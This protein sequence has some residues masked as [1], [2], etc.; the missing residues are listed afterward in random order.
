MRSGSILKEEEVYLLCKS[1]P[2]E[3][4]EKSIQGRLEK[5]LLEHLARLEK[6]I[7]AGR[8]KKR[9]KIHQRIGRLRE[10]YSKV[11][12]YYDMELQE[13]ESQLKLS[14]KR[15]ED[16][17]ERPSGTYLLRTNRQDLSEEEIWQLYSLLTQ[18]E[19]SFRSL[20]S[21]L[22]M[23]PIYHQREGRAEAHIFLSLLA[24]HLLH[25]I[26]AVLR[27]KGDHRSW[28]TIKEALSSQARV[29]VS[30][31]AQNGLGYHIRLCTIPEKEHLEIY[32]ALHLDPIPLPRRR[33]TFR[34]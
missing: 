31:A 20:K 34:L 8:L 29:T 33:A 27:A 25:S 13:E 23:R 6:S 14:Y 2:K 1:K 10:R 22:G 17:K 7:A 24:Y 26:E 3:L 18:V 15:R 30:L 9:D 32:Q 4:K 28:K 19:D 12:Q 11:A 21:H 5:I 16:I